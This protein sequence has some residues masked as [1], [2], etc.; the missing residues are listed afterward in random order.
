MPSGWERDIEEKMDYGVFYE[1]V[2]AAGP[3][4]SGNGGYDL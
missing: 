1:G 4:A 2:D 3:Q